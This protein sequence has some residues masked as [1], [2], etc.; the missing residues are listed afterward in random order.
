MI[1]E[2]RTDLGDHLKMPLAYYILLKFHLLLL[3]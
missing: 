2:I 1:A 3:G